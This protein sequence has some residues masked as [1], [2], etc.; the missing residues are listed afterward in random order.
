MQAKAANSEGV[1]IRQ[2]IVCKRRADLRAVKL[3][4]KTK[5]EMR[6]GYRVLDNYR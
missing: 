3:G 6:L 4:Q 1:C 2:N 5:F